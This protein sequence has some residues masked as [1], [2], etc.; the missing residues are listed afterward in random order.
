MSAGGSHL[1]AT[2]AEPCAVQP[3]A[4]PAQITMAGP[5]LNQPSR[6]WAARRRW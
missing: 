5:V 3:E 6:V 4:F 2:G 1:H